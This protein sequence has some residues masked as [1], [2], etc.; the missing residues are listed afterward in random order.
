MYQKSYTCTEINVLLRFSDLRTL[1]LR[2]NNVRG[3]T[4]PEI[5]KHFNLRERSQSWHAILLSLSNSLYLYEFNRYLGLWSLWLQMTF[6]T[7]ISKILGFAVLKSLYCII[8]CQCHH[9]PLHILYFMHITFS[10]CQFKQ[11]WCWGIN[12]MLYF[13]LE[14]H[15]KC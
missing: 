4:F 13:T 6:K 9:P 2:Y 11:V 5:Q 15:K 7:F 10:A 3:P 14:K 8:L 1:I 12:Q